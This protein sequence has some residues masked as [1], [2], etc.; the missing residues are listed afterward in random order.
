M[1]AFDPMPINDN[2]L[3]YWAGRVI[4]P[5]WLPTPTLMILMNDYPLGE[6]LGW[7]ALASLIV[8]VPCVIAVVV[9]QAR[10]YALH[11]RGIRRPL[12]VL[13]IILLLLCLLVLL[14]LQAP[15][16]LIACVIS[17]LIWAP[18]QAVINAFVTKIS[19]H[20]AVAAGCAVGLL[21]SGKITSG[22]AAVV[23]VGLAFAVMWARVRTHNHTLAQVISGALVGAL[24]VLLVFAAVSAFRV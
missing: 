23:I 6:V 1:I 2:R 19:G 20:A 11:Q 24:P 13:G 10:G 18:L 17:G 14:A 12:Y 5:Y 9:F 7:L 3:A 16:V 21:V 4:H 22:V 8:L 15:P